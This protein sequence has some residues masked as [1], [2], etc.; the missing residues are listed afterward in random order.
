MK[1][2]FTEAKSPRAS[3]IERHWRSDGW[4][5]LALVVVFFWYVVL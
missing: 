2:I 3:I 4:C 1:P 5:L